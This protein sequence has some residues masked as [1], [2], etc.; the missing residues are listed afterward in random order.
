[1]KKS[2]T[3]EQIID[4]LREGEIGAMSIEALCNEHNLTEQTL[5]RWCN[6]FDRVDSSDARRLKDLGSQS[7]RLRL[8]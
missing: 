7:A 3:D 1:M 2:L 5:F 4:I 8:Q 6:K